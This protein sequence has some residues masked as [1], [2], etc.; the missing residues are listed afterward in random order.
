M[1]VNTRAEEKK[2]QKIDARKHGRWRHRADKASGA[3]RPSPLREQARVTT[4]GKF[5]RQRDHRHGP[6]E[7]A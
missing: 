7:H 2:N 6:A 1:E 4:E 3:F 5:Q